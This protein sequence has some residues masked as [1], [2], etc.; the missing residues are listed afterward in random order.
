MKEL[1]HLEVLRFCTCDLD[2]PFIYQ[3][4][5]V[6]QFELTVELLADDSTGQ[7][8]SSS[9]K[10]VQHLQEPSLLWI[11]PN[12]LFHGVCLDMNGRF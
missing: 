12:C 10:L 8:L 5:H 9:L 1:D 6:T 4:H 7:C 3:V 11:W 2:I